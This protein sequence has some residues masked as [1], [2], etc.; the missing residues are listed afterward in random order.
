M[1]SL[2]LLLFLAFTIDTEARSLTCPALFIERPQI[3]LERD[4]E[5]K[6][7]YIRLRENM[8]NAD[9]KI[10]AL[11]LSQTVILEVVE[12]IGGYGDRGHN[13]GGVFLVKTPMGPKALKVLPRNWDELI[14]ISSGMTNRQRDEVI[15][16]NFF[17]DYGLA[18]PIRG[19]FSEKD[20]S[21]LLNRLPYL[22][23]NLRHFEN[24]KSA[25]WTAYLMDFIPNAW[26]PKKWGK[27]FEIS[28]PPPHAKNWDLAAIQLQIKEIAKLRDALKIHLRDPQVLISASGKMY[29]IDFGLETALHRDDLTGSSFSPPEE[30]SATQNTF[31]WLV[32]M[33]Y[34]QIP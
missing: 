19:T 15:L 11:S 4:S 26:N 32:Q 22:K 30:N 24:Y 9:E 8:A 5:W 29:A 10:A 23:A 20:T 7:E 25:Q 27:S 21:E 14:D 18:V 6:S 3:S 12:P 16:Q 34:K 28:P 13:P 31:E 1:N 33:I 17:A 2:I